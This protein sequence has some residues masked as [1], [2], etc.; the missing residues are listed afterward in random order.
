[1]ALAGAGGRAR[2]ERGP[3]WPGRGAAGVT[4]EA[5]ASR[6][7]AMR[8]GRPEGSLLSRDGWGGGRGRGGRGGRGGA[9]GGRG[10]EQRG[11]GGIS[12][13]ARA[14]YGPTSSQRGGGGVYF[15]PYLLAISSVDSAPHPAAT[16]LLLF[17]FFQPERCGRPPFRTANAPNTSRRLPIW[18]VSCSVI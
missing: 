10:A 3:A 4:A 15:P 17:S 5:G 2:G 1:M 6:R 9:G 18:S 14:P 8:A 12:G 11:R 16:H 7:G 13:A